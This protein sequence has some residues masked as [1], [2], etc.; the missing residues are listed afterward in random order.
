MVN[1]GSGVDVSI[2][3]LALTIKKVVDFDGELTFNTD[4]PDG[5]PRKLMDVS[6]LEKIGWKYSINLEEGISAVYKDVIEN[7]VF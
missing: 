1:I 4:K 5:T 3:E 7:K 6:K 2:K